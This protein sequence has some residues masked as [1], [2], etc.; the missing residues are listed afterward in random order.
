MQISHWVATEILI[1]KST[2][3][4]VQ[5][6]EKFIRLASHC[7]QLNNFNTFMEIVSGSCRPFR[8]FCAAHLL[9]PV[10]LEK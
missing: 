3:M 10:L 1:T 8:P 6:L 9:N 2:G 4:Q 5:V 7:L